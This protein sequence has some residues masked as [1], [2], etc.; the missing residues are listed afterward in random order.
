[1]IHQLPNIITVIR[2]VLVLPVLWC[3][4]TQQYAVALMLFAVAGFSDGLDGYLARRFNWQSRFGEVADPLADKFMLISAFTC[5]WWHGWVPWWLF[6]VIVLR[7]VFIVVG[8]LF[9]HWRVRRVDMSPT[10]ISKINTFCQ[11]VLVL[12]MMF[13]AGVQ[14]LPTAL[15]EASWV[16][17][18][19]TTLMTGLDYGWAWSWKTYNDSVALGSH[20]R[21][22]QQ[23]ENIDES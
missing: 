11:I 22:P 9:Y 4:I 16:A 5:L 23:R 7:D 12:G 18:F 20:N 6:G 1:M 3:L 21:A 2:I 17:V 8:A 14:P 13:H 15:V 19:V 10:I